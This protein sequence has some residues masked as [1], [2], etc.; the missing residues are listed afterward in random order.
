MSD[1]FEL[2][3]RYRENPVGSEGRSASQRKS[4]RDPGWTPSEVRLK[5]QLMKQFQRRGK[6]AGD[7]NTAAFRAG[8]DGIDWGA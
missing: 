4:G 2:G 1:G 8:Y 6:G 7:G 3:G 5:S